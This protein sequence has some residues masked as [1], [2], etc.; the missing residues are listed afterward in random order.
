MALGCNATNGLQLIQTLIWTL[1]LTITSNP[2]VDD[3]FF[4]VFVF[5]YN[6]I[7]Y[8]IQWYSVAAPGGGKGGQMTPQNY[9]LPPHF[10]PPQK[11]VLIT[12]S[13]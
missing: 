13:D 9:F 4:L 7:L 5:S 10:A 11:N 2:K 12:E 1:I 8:C 6:P 3:L